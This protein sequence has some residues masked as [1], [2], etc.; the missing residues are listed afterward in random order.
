MRS[1]AVL[2]VLAMVSL[3]GCATQ[4]DLESVR[5]DSDEMK[6]R[7]FTLEKGLGDVR[8]EVK[9]GV[10]RS[11]TGYQQRLEKFQKEIEGYQNEMASIRKSG[12]DLQATLDNARVDMQ[13]LTG[14]VDDLRIQAQKPADELALMK[15]DISKRLAA[16]EERVGKLEQAI[17]DQQKKAAEAQQTPEAQYQQALDTMKAGDTAKAR[18][19]FTK[20]LEQNPKHKL[21]A[22]A[23]YWLG[24]T[25]YSD[26]NYE[27]AILEFQDVIKNYPEKDK[28]PA[29]L[30]KQG[31][32]FRGLG[33]TK[34][35]NYVF[36]KLID[37]YPKSDEARTARE[38][39]RG[40]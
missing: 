18:E 38:K 26:K 40:K 31:M 5:R 9:E 4:A 20:F 8:G 36:R 10:E 3:A 27:Q 21:A 13:V 22:N 29:A 25:Y 23:H 39:L 35:S 37:E 16:L 15:D 14:K 28:V 2:V 6:S 12:A 32:A 34:S 1:W 24:E 7:I 33:D 30:L 17:A 19:L 11:L